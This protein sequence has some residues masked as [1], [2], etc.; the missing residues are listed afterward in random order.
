MSGVGWR[1]GRSF[2]CEPG[3]RPGSIPG[4]TRDMSGHAPDVV[5]LGKALYTNFLTPPRCEWVPNFV[6]GRYGVQR[7]ELAVREDILKSCGRASQMQPPDGEREERWLACSAAVYVC[8]TRDK[9]QT[10]LRC[11][12]SN[13]WNV[14]TFLCG[15]PHL[16]SFSTV[17][18]MS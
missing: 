18:V 6:C 12:K 8:W 5:L 17:S 11:F 16:Q 3:D 13:N 7:A 2:D 14:K 9:R 4:R 1:S 15:Q 10:Y